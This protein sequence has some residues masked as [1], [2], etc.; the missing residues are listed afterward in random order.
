MK[1]REERA[2]TKKEMRKP[3]GGCTSG[4]MRTLLLALTLC[5]AL[6]AAAGVVSKPVAYTIGKDA[7]E[8]VLVY[9][10]AVKTARPGLLLVPNWLGITPANVKQAELVAGSK[11]V[12]FVA[13]TYG[14]NT[15]PKTQED[16]GKMSGALKADRK[17]LRERIVKA[18]DIM[19]SQAK[20]A[21][22]DTA[23]LGAVGF[24]FGGT[25]AIELAR[26]GAKIAGVAAFHA[27]LD[28]PTP[29]D[30]KNITAKILALH[31]ADDPYNPAA[32]VEAFENEM[33]TNK[34]DW[35]LVK[36]G[37]AVHSFTDVDAHMAGQADY[38]PVVAKRAYEAMNAFFGELFAG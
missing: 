16:A 10:D 19:K 21:N 27:G 18:F 33:R 6:P 17:T 24:C 32:N 1:K 3:F 9:D 11:Y 25:T 12:V 20:V 14:K 5:V 8:G 7:Y 37:G 29:A 23:K 35:Q 38:N 22:I 30:G 36:Y 34:V 15:R 2:V 28:S 26:T 4:H 13:D 31:G